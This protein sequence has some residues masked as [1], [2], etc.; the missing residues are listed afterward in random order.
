[1]EYFVK[2]LL[3]FLPY[4][5]GGV[6]CLAGGY[7]LG[8]SKAPAAAPYNASYVKGLNYL[9]ANLPDKAI[10]EFTKAVKINSDTVEIYLRLGN[11]FRDKGEVERAIRIH[12]SIILRPVLSRTDKID[13]LTELG[14]DYLKAGFIDRSIETY[15]E[16]L[17]LQSDHLEAHIRLAEL[18]E[19]ERNWEKAFSFHQKILRLKKSGDKHILANIQVE[20]GKNFLEKQDIKQAV[21][22]FNTAILLDKRSTRAYLLLGRIYMDQEKVKKAIDIWKDIIDKDLSFASLTY[23]NLET[24][25]HT[26]GHPEQA[27]EIYREVL[28]RKPEY[29]RTRLVL[30]KFHYR[31]GNPRQAIEELREVLKRGI[32]FQAAREYLFKILV[33]QV[34]SLDVLSEYH[35]LFTHLEMEDVPYRCRICG[36]ESWD[37]PWNCPQCRQWDSFTDPLNG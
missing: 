21:K 1:M 27:E 36:Y 18:Y 37:S 31:E 29:V 24:A 11:L 26:L 25:H 3:E 2:Y 14:M 16:I 9:I 19:E 17:T 28:K 8:K 20:I 23:K 15:S 34:R 30:A 12:Q 13:A 35:E 7:I 10:A 4:L 33:D 32:G 5:T 6:V 22:R